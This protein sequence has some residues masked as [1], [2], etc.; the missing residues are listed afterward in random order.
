MAVS[1]SA[2]AQLW[3]WGFFP[4]APIVK[5]KKTMQ[6]DI[7]PKHREKGNRAFFGVEHRWLLSP[8]EHLLNTR[9]KVKD[10]QTRMM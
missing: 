5:K 4:I 9:L 6:Q 2:D 10:P 7:D 8:T 3:G 1:E